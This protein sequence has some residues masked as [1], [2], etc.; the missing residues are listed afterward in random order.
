MADP[1]P[2]MPFLGASAP[3]LDDE[4]VTSA[5]VRRQIANTLRDRLRERTAILNNAQVSTDDLLLEIRRQVSDLNMGGNLMAAAETLEM[6]WTLLSQ[7]DD[8]L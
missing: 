7:R 2:T 6:V 5:H 1:K 4:E 3:W 8:G